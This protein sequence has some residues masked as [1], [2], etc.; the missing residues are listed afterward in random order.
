[1]PCELIEIDAMR[2]RQEPLH[3]FSGL[4][5]AIDW[6]DV[7]LQS[8]LEELNLASF[9]RTQSMILVHIARDVKRPSEIAREM[10]TTRQNIHAMANQLIESQVIK[11][12]DDPLDGRAKQ[13]EFSDDA[14]ELRDTVLHILSHLDS[15][16]AARV[17][18]ETVQALHRAFSVDWG[19][20]V[21]QAPED[22]IESSS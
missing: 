7:S 6:Y 8:I 16:L 4:V 15:I 1:M 10:G 9:N 20:Y 14:L 2:N 18:A 17:G 11:Q 12:V 19:D 22:I 5:K 3:I 13:Y 21:T